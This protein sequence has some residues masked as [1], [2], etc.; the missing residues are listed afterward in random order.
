VAGYFGLLLLW[1]SWATLLAGPRHIPTP[2]VIM[3][4]TVPLLPWLRGLLYDRRNAYLWLGLLSLAYFIH[5]VGAFA[6]PL[7]RQP[8]ALEIL[9]SVTLF[10]GCL[11]RLKR[12]RH[13]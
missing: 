12:K 6:N 4:S 9:F 2:L 13:A 5:G 3:A 11:L 10:G 1:V 8:A 7:E